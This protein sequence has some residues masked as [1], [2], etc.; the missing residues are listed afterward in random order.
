M[1]QFSLGGIISPF[2]FSLSFLLSPFPPPLGTY[3]WRNRQLWFSKKKATPDLN[4]GKQVV[5]NNVC[6]EPI[7]GAKHPIPQVVYRWRISKIR[8]IHFQ[9]GVNININIYIHTRVSCVFLMLPR[10]HNPE[11]EVALGSPRNMTT[12][13]QRNI[14]SCVHILFKTL[15]I[16]DFSIHTSIHIC[17]QCTFIGRSHFSNDMYIL[18]CNY[19]FIYIYIY[20][21][22]CVCAVCYFDVF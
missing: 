19:R 21:H 5:F 7:D 22:T 16:C 10:S 15:F 9:P 6:R 20:I 13:L 12:I 14:P 4:R 8:G 2:P 18:L 11:A 3:R 1:A 17:M